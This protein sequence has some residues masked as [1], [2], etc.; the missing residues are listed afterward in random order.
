MQEPSVRTSRLAIIS[1]LAAVIVVGGGGFVLGRATA[2]KPAPAPP[3]VVAPVPAPTII[4]E[5]PKNLERRDL[6][7]L[8]QRAADAFASGDTVPKSVSET[9]GQRFELLLPFGCSGPSDAGSG[10]PMRWNYDQEAGTLRVTV[11][12]TIWNAGD[13][14]EGDRAGAGNAEGFWITRPWSSSGICPTQAKPA[15]PRGTDPITL[16]GQT[17]AIAQFFDGGNDR[18]ERRS[19][20]PLQIVQRTG[21]ERLDTSKGFRLRITGRIEA[22]AGS[23]PV[24]CVQP[25]G[26][27][28]RPICVIGARIDSIEL[29][30]PTTERTLATWSIRRVGQ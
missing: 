25:A 4:P 23:A 12:P 18:G 21:A 5:R 20:R 16:P 9:T 17:L 15:V 19:S 1:G 27:E 11:E 2:P 6:T 14:G 30:N 29:E 26:S 3:P 10:A 7:A 22:I 24:R 8:A 28:Q 13:W